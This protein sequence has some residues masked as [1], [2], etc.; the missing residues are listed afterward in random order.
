MVLCLCLSSSGAGI[1]KND[2]GEIVEIRLDMRLKDYDRT[3]DH[4]VSFTAI[5]TLEGKD[6]AFSFRSEGN[7]KEH[8]LPKKI[9]GKKVFSYFQSGCEFG[10][11][12]D[13][14]VVFDNLLKELLG[15]QNEGSLFGQTMNLEKTL[16]PINRPYAE[17]YRITDLRHM[18][19]TSYEIT[20]ILDPAYDSLTMYLSLE[21]GYGGTPSSVTTRR[22][23]Y[24][25]K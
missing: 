20:L 12:D 14:S 17:G 16:G 13:R 24:E 19:S 25:Q 18:P 4:A 7:W 11:V 1:L 21:A 6:V 15:H 10:V 22:K 3:E 5:G 8:F 23:L 9:K 2:D